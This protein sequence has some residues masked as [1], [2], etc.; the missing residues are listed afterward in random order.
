LNPCVNDLSLTRN[1]LPFKL[2]VIVIIELR[3]QRTFPSTSYGRCSFMEP[4]GSRQESPSES[5]LFIRDSAT[6][7]ISAL[8]YIR[9]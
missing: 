5:R 9:C 8:V 4:N 2:V 6:P 7:S 3:Q 1:G